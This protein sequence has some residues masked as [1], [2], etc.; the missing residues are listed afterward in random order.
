MIK[1]SEILSE[2]E[3]FFNAAWG[4]EP[5]DL[6]SLEALELP[7]M[8]NMPCMLYCSF[9]MFWIG[10]S[11]QFLRAAAK[12]KTASLE[13]LCWTAS[14]ECR[15]H[16]S[17][18]CKWNVPETEKLVIDLGEYFAGGGVSGY[19]EF[20]EVITKALVAIDTMQNRVDAEI[21]WARMD[22]A[23]GGVNHPVEK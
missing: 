2:I 10:E 22:K 19:D 7:P 6:K 8:G 20:I 23:L 16:A 18:L 14:E 12:D 13:T 17:R 9:N 5:S 15:R 4:K 21:P 3:S 11:F 1:T